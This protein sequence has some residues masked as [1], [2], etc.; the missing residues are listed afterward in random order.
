M[1]RAATRTSM[2]WAKPAIVLPTMYNAMATTY[3]GLRPK[4]SESFPYTGMTIA[5]ARMKAVNTHA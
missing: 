3:R 4:T 1:A 2:L 5:D